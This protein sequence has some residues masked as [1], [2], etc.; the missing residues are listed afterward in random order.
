M[1]AGQGRYDE[2]LRGASTAVEN[3]RGCA[4]P[5]D[6]LGWVYLKMG[7]PT[8]ARAAFERA[9]G[10]APSEPLY[11]QHAD[12]ARRAVARSEPGTAKR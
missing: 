8:D 1:L 4:E 6:T 12:E 7:R 2:A 3:L 5:Q 11:S 10:I 9:R